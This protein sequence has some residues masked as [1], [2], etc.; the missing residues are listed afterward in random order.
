MLLEIKPIAGKIESQPLNDNFSVLDSK[1]EQKADIDSVEQVKSK[2]NNI[3]KLK[4]VENAAGENRLIPT[5]TIQDDDT[6]NQLYDL[7]FPL[8]QQKNIPISSALISG[9]IGVNPNTITYAQFLEMKDSG[10]VEFVNHTHT[11]QRL[12]ELTEEEIDYEIRTCQEWLE[13]EGVYTKHLVY[14]FGAYNN[15]IRRVA[16][17]YVESATRYGG[18][19]FDPSTDVLDSYLITRVSFELDTQ[20]IKN[21]IDGAVAN[22]GW[23]IL[24]THAQYPTFSVSKLEE[25]IDYAQGLGC[26]FLKYS[27][28]YELYGNISEIRDPRTGDLVSAISSKGFGRGLP[29]LDVQHPSFVQDPTISSPPTFFDA[30]KVSTTTFSAERAQT[31][32]FPGAGTLYTSRRH[33]DGY[34]YQWFVPYRSNKVMYR[35]WHS[36][37]SSWTNFEEHLP[38]AKDTYFIDQTEITSG[39]GRHATYSSPIFETGKTIS[40]S[41][42]FELP[43]G[44]TYSVSLIQNGQARLRIY[45]ISSSSITL[46]AGNWY[47]TSV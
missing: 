26:Q 13:N 5:I 19:Y 25:I 1:I 32:G 10:L 7:I 33:N 8:I 36:S 15:T 37:Q 17:R 46:P 41:P 4:N 38:I 40:V 47:F 12:D 45:N 14:P 18:G 29:G 3:P 44:L 39:G 2:V 43:N 16:A 6:R 9:R 35:Y 30:M 21:L 11:H 31:A 24:N 20:E 34:T 23:I 42:D 27:D 28:A 22:N